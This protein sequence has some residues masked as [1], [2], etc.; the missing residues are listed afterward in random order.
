LRAD[1]HALV[2]VDQGHMIELRVRPAALA[3]YSDDGM[4]PVLRR[5]PLRNAENNHSVGSA[6]RELFGP[7]SVPALNACP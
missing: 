2:D 1:V 3:G 4:Y 5:E 6:T 7:I